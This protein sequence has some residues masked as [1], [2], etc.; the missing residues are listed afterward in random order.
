M[1]QAT[2]LDQLYYVVKEG[3]GAIDI[4]LVIYPM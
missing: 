2:K 3:L 1:Q 4:D